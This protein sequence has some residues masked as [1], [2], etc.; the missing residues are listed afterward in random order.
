MPAYVARNGGYRSRWA[1]VRFDSSLRVDYDDS[2][3]ENTLMWTTQYHERLR[4]PSVDGTGVSYPPR[5]KHLHDS[6]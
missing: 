2:L 4:T 3:S 1:P 5:P 6:H